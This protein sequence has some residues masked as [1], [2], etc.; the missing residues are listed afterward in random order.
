MT[1]KGRFAML[2]MLLAFTACG[3]GGE[4]GGSDIP[5]VSASNLLTVA[6]V[7]QVIAQAVAEASARNLPATIAVVDRVGN[8]LGVF[9]MNGAPVTVTISSGTSATGG[10]VGAMVPA[11]LAAISKAITGA[12]LSSAGNA[13]STRTASQIVQDHFN[14]Q[15]SN[16]P[17][18]P[19][20]GVQFSQLSCSDLNRQASEGSIGPKR[21]PLGF[22]AD[23]G[24][25]E[26]IF[27]TPDPQNSVSLRRQLPSFQHG[28]LEF[29]G[30][31]VLLECRI[32]INQ[33]VYESWMIKNLL[34]CKAPCGLMFG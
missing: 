31:G 5:P 28:G 27:Y 32:E 30:S 17:G 1:A 3:G 18:G 12:Y 2:L 25:L 8:V 10:L 19:L 29:W 21:S 11:T 34:S 20:F 6:D 22:A 13:F 26:G 14:P 23:P 7:Q 4:G 9:Q 33:L 16:Q 15:E 24:G